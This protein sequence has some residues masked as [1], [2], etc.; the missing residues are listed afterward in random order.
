MVVVDAV[1]AD[2][3]P[4]ILKIQLLRRDGERVQ[5]IQ[6]LMSAARGEKPRRPSSVRYRQKGQRYKEISKDVLAPP[7]QKTVQA[8][9]LAFFL[10][11]LTMGLFSESTTYT[12]T[13]PLV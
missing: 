13:R 9:W 1:A 5:Y 8:G 10:Y 3:W 12:R 6:T 7:L 2:S 4:E 11:A